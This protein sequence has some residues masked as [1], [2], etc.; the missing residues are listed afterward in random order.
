MSILLGID[1]SL[2]GRRLHGRAAAP[3]GRNSTARS[4]AW[5]LMVGRMGLRGEH[6]IVNGGAGAGDSNEPARNVTRRAAIGMV[7]L[8]LDAWS[9][10]DLGP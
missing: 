3:R 5:R 8:A 1:Y 9:Q 4:G 10:H 7:V 6:C 2:D